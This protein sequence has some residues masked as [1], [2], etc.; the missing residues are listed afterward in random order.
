MPV[1]SLRKRPSASRGQ[2]PLHNHVIP[3]KA[4]ASADGTSIQRGW[5]TETRPDSD[6]IVKFVPDKHISEMCQT[7]NPNPLGCVPPTTSNI[8]LTTTPLRRVPSPDQSS[9]QFVPT[10]WDV[11]ENGCSYP[12]KIVIHEAGQVFGMGHPAHRNPSC[13]GACPDGSSRSA[14]RRRTTSWP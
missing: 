3:A 5:A 12:H 1:D 2:G 9:D 14:S 8:L 4:G 11:M 6:D 10:S 7:G 13:I